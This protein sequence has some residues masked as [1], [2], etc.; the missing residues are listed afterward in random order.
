MARSGRL[1][2]DFQ[3]G[4]AEYIESQNDPRIAE[5]HLTRVMQVALVLC[6]IQ[7]TIPS[8]AFFFFFFFF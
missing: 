6:S 8:G 3:E 4:S 1:A 5:L 7:T 2:A